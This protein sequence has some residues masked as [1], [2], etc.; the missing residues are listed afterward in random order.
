GKADLI[1]G[2]DLVVSGARKVLS[3]VREN[4]TIFVANTAEIM[5]GEF[6]RSA[7]YSLPIERLKKAIRQAAGEEKAHF[8]DATRTASVLFGDS[9]GA[10]M[11][12][13]GFAYQHGGLPLSAEAIEKAIELNGQAVAMNVDAF[14]WGRRAAHEPEFVRRLVASSRNAAAGRP[15]SEALDAVV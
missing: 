9:L 15:W 8:F 11:F 12:M 3:A 14:R 6:A 1:L 4:H 7:D 10:N 5:P 13:L 2:C